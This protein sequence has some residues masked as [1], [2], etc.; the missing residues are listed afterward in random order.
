M[1]IR[2]I[3]V[4]GAS[5]GGVEAL[6][7]LARELPANLQ[8]ALFAVLHVP[9]QGTSVLPQ[10]LA[11]TGSLPAEHAQHGEQIRLGRWYVAPPDKHLLLQRS[12]FIHLGRGPAENGHRPAVD[13]LFRSAAR[14][15]GSRVIG[16]ILSGALDDG[17]AGLLAVK[18][19]G[20]VAIVQDPAE[21][22]YASMPRSAIENVEVDHVASVRDLARL[23][24][25]LAGEPI[26][27][28]ES[29]M[30]TELEDAG[31]EVA[32]AEDGQSALDEQQRRGVPSAFACPD[33]HGVLWESRDGELVRYRCRVGHAY[34]PLAL[35]D[36]QSERLEESLWIALRTLKESSALSK[37]MASRARERRMA[38]VAATYDTR[39]TE[40]DARAAVIEDVLKRGRLSASGAD[41][42]MLETT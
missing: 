12:G 14:A 38:Q 16:V 9:P 36:A 32:V 29:I 33:C 37:R 28:S 10:L 31:D 41:A 34:L 8:A 17:T 18:L 3:V 13:P 7:N 20:G 15:Y 21:S 11:R 22:L 30:S 19:G 27:R 42:S 25:R 4:V 5:A 1:P 23:I 6:M 35:A 24:A 39:A 40:A 26:P 2:N